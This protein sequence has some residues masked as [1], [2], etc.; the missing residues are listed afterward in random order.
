LQLF[1]EAEFPI[2]KTFRLTPQVLEGALIAFPRLFPDKGP[3]VL[4]VPEVLWGIDT[5][6]WIKAILRINNF[7]VIK[8][9]Y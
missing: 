6:Y 5:V 8:L 4:V 9:I 1:P 2:P 3:S 7:M